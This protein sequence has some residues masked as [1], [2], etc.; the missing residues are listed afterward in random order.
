MPAVNVKR[1]SRRA[2]RSV[3]VSALTVVGLATAALAAAGTVN[4]A[5]APL[6][7]RSGPGT[8]YSNVGSVR[9]GAHT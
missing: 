2:A 4:T 1:T 3:G 5:G 7:V 9:D 8:G 6:T